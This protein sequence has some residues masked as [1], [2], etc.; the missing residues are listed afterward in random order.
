[1]SDTDVKRKK[2]SKSKKVEVDA[3]EQIVADAL[4]DVIDDAPAQPTTKPKKK[5]KKSAKPDVDNENNDTSPTT[6]DVV[7]ETSVVA[8]PPPDA[9]QCR[10]STRRPAASRKTK[11]TAKR[12]NLVKE[13]RMEMMEMVTMMMRSLSQTPTRIC[14]QVSF[15]FLFF[16]C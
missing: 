5:K 16:H 13:R 10:S 9:R 12:G 8:T 2:K 3:N 4:S 6:N 11:R 15:F 7:P 14:H 1:M